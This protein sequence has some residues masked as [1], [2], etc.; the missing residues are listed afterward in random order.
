M[1]WIQRMARRVR[2]LVRRSAAEEAMD[3]EFRHHLECEIA[4]RIRRGMTHDEA[5]RTALR[6]FGGIEAI[7]EYAR[8]ERGGRA[9]DDLGRDL[10]YAV[11]VLR[12]NPVYTVLAVL[13]F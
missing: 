4:D 3:D 13:T 10:A 2:L 6:D 12:R 1:Q 11:R 7:K 8:D 5:R 9:L